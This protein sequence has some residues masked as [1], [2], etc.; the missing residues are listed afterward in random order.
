MTSRPAPAS[1][2]DEGS[3]NARPP[4]VTRYRTGQKVRHGKFGDGIVIESQSTGADE[5]V[6]VAFS[7]VGIK[8]LAASFANLTSLDDS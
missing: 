5:E 2:V 1:T 8:R 7:D 6:T 3:V 4:G